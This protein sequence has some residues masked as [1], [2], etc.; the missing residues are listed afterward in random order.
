MRP[1]DILVLDM[2]L[3]A[4]ESI[5]FLSGISRDAFESDRIRQLAVIK[6]IETIGEAAAQ[7]SGAF[8]DAHSE[9]PWPDIVGMRNRLVHGYFEISLDRVWR[10]VR[11]DMPRLL[12]LLENIVGPETP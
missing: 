6:S 2:L 10:T 1:D 3:A 8:R 5:E 4:R 9:I 7:V 11:E 12:Q